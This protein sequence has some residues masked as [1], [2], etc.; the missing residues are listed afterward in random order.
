MNQ[1]RRPIRRALAALTGLAMGANGAVML[2]AGRWWYG[3]VPGVTETGPFNPHFVRDIGAA[4]LTAGLALGWLGLAPSREARGAAVAAATFLGL[5][6]AIHLG[7]AL[8]DPMGLAHLVRDFAGVILPALV[9]AALAWPS[10]P[11]PET[12]HA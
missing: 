9:A 12:R 3:D 1:E 4:Y 5:H 8:T 11:Q 6:A 10:V 7:G 2:A